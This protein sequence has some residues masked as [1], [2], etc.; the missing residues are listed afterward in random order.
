MNRFIYCSFL[1]T[2]LGIVTATSAQELAPLGRP[3]KQPDA[4]QVALG[5]QLF[6]DPRL[7]GDATLSCAT[8]HI[9]EK[10]WTDGAPLSAGYPG[11]KY[12]RN[13][14][15]ILNAAESKSLYWDGRLA[16]SDIPTMVRDH[17]SEAHFMQADGRLVIERMRQVPEY[18]QAF[19][20]TFGGEPTYGR[21]LNS[22]AAFVKTLRST[23]V[24]FDQFLEGKKDAISAKAKR[25]LEL[26]KGKA[27]CIKC[28][29]GKMLSDG[30]FHNLGIEAN[31][32]IFKEPQRH[33]SWRRFFRTLGVAE[34]AKLRRDLGRYAVTKQPADRF[35]FRTPTLR[36]IE[37][38]APYMHNGT[39]KTL[40]DVVKFYDAGGGPGEEK[41]SELKPLELT[42]AEQADLAAFLKTL[43]GKPIVVEKP[44]LPKYKLRERG[45]N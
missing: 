13:V 44:E 7:S 14:P 33:I 11:T 45:R 39:L 26:F 37:R 9:P 40:A 4:Q 41:S 1:I 27:G 38:T 6:F 8:C 35:A 18:E 16:A 15:T 32:T 29:H 12:F 31:P 42:D 19:N 28:H 5:K 21:I 2:T 23:E 24:P 17:I 25:G 10:G 43:S 34:Y 3:E 36:E 30:K 22:V 20:S